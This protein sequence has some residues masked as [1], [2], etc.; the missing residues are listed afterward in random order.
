[1]QYDQIIKIRRGKGRLIRIN[2]ICI[3]LTDCFHT[4]KQQTWMH[5]IIMIKKTNKITGCHRKT[6]IGIPGDSQVLLDLLIFDPAVFLYILLTDPA[7]ICMLVITSIC[8][9]QFPVLVG[10]CHYRIDHFPQELLRGIVQRHQNTDLDLSWKYSLFLSTSLLCIR[11][12]FCSK[13]QTL[14]RFSFFLFPA[15]VHSFESTVMNIGISGTDHKMYHY[16]HRF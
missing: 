2:I 12:R 4:L 13:I 14:G 10:L 1:M 5:H 6:Y 7:H 9:T 15:T 3:F 11:E 16:P 8:Q